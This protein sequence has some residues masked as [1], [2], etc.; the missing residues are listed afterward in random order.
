MKITRQF[1]YLFK[2]DESKDR[3][4]NEILNEILDDTFKKK[5][6]LHVDYYFIVQRILS[7]KRP[8][9]TKTT[10]VK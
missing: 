5:S 3:D 4:F 8:V 2:R 10:I 9:K 1:K 7:S 6:N